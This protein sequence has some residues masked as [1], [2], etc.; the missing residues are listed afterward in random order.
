MLIGFVPVCRMS[1]L[2][3]RIIFESDSRARRPLCMF[4]CYALPSRYVRW[5][6]NTR[7]AHLLC[8]AT[9]VQFLPFANF[10]N[11]N[12]GYRWVIWQD[13]IMRKRCRER[14]SDALFATGY[15]KA[16]PRFVNS[17]PSVIMSAWP[18]FDVNSTTSRKLLVTSMVRLSLHMTSSLSSIAQYL[19]PSRQVQS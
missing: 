12:W 13:R 18:E 11:Q 10:A 8:H 17:S 5:P 19:Q 15:P 2:V 14:L 1:Q 6:C 7:R 3:V 16:S 4:F 9:Q